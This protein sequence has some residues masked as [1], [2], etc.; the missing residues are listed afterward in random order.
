MTAEE[1]RLM[2]LGQAMER[3]RKELPPGQALH[4]ELE[5]G[6]QLLPSTARMK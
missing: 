5:H 4:I 2:A 6:K 3:V 1:K